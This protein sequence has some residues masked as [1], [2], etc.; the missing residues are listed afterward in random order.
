M[1]GTS[2]TADLSAASA[3][4]FADLAALAA[5]MPGVQ[6]IPGG[7]GS[8]NGFSVFGLSADQNA[9]TLNG[10]SFGGSTLPRDA[11]VSA[12][13]VTTPYDVS[14]GGF[15]GGQMTLRADPGSNYIARLGGVN[16]DAPGLQWTDR[17]ARSLGQQYGN[18]SVGG[19]V[20]GPIQFDRSFYSVAY[21]AGRRWSDYQTLLN[22]DAAG[23]RAAGLAPDSAVRVLSALARAGVPTSI[24]V[25]PA[26][27]L[28]DNT[29]VFGTI[30]YVPSAT[31]GQAFNLTFNGAWVRQD[32]AQVQATQ[33]PSRAGE[34]ESWYGGAQLRQSDYYGAG[35]LSETSVGVNRFRV[36]GRSVRRSAVGRGPGQFCI[37]RRDQRRA[38]SRVRGHVRLRH[39]ALD[40]HRAAHESALLVHREQRA[41]A[42]A[43]DRPSS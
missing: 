40:D 39:G 5:S 18:V 23:L 21:Q 31:S 4:P 37:R 30:D 15:S 13:L 19:R 35:V 9:T 29:S 34:R 28:T 36:D 14:R 33:T 17:A 10:M 26:S 11:A 6:F 8:P 1:S 43:Y 25:V 12:S 38:A 32:P 7:D 24:G 22:T 42:E 2:R 41:P 16:V 27:R 3:D 20:T